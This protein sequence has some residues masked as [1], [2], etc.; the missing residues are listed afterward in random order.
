MKVFPDNSSGELRLS[1]QLRQWLESHDHFHG[2]REILAVI[3]GRALLRLDG[4][5]VR[6]SGLN[7]RQKRQ[8]RAHRLADLVI[9]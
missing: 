2:N 6:I 3:S 1:A 8:L 9:G 4:R 7:R 5:P